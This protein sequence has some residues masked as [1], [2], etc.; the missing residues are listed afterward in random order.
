MVHC[1]HLFGYSHTEIASIVDRS[2]AAV[3]QTASRA[4]AHVAARRPRFDADTG[5]R[6][7]VAERFREACAGGDLKAMMDLLAPDVVGWSDGGGKVTAARRPPRRRGQPGPRRRADRRPAPHRQPRQAD[8]TAPGT[9][10][11]GL[12]RQGLT[13]QGLTQTGQATTRA[14][15]PATAGRAPRAPGTARGHGWWC[16]PAWCKYA[17]DRRAGARAADPARHPGGPPAPEAAPPSGP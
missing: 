1:R 13:R 11:Q 17:R 3:R 15:S 5:V 8:R 9:A 12:T 6:V 2:E 4:R 10:A 14:G 7:A 16:P